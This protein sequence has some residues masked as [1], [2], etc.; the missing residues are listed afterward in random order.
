MDTPANEEAYRQWRCYDEERAAAAMAGDENPRLRA[1]QYILFKER[2]VDA[3]Q[4]ADFYLKV[5]DFLSNALIPEQESF[6]DS[7]LGTP[8]K[9]NKS[10][11]DQLVDSPA[12]KAGICEGVSEVAVKEAVPPENSEAP[13]QAEEV[14]GIYHHVVNEVKLQILTM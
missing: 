8:E 10:R 3:A 13:V 5:M 12:E 7:A 4:D 14:E 1:F 11:D 9:P 6:R 2:G